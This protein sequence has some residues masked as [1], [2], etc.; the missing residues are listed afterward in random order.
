MTKEEIEETKLACI[1]FLSGD[2]I[3]IDFGNGNWVDV[4]GNETTIAIGVYPFRRKPVPP[5]PQLVPWDCKQDF[6]LK[7]SPYSVEEEF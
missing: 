2:P 7:G 5:V 4:S 1:A 3:Q 6:P